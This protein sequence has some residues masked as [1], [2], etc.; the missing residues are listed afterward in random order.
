M[1]WI[2][3]TH[4]LSAIVHGYVNKEDL[5]DITNGFHALATGL[6]AS[7]YLDYVA[8]KANIADLPSRGQFELPRQL[9]A[10]VR[11]AG[12]EVP[13][14]HQLRGPLTWWVDVGE[15]AALAAGGAEW[16]A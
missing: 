4:A 1:Q 3:N 14:I 9:G 12:M 11:A 16:P 13:T 10:T 7:T 8:S 15:R 5:A 6:R 2:D